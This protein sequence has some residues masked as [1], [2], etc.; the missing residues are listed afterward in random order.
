[1]RRQPSAS[2][3]TAHSLNA[4]AVN[5]LLAV[6]N[7]SMT[8]RSAM[9]NAETKP[10]KTQHVRSK[11]QPKILYESGSSIEE[12]RSHLIVHYAGTWD[13]GTQSRHSPFLK[14][15]LKA[16]QGWDKAAWADDV[17]RRLRNVVAT[18]DPT[19]QI[20]GYTI[21]RLKNCISIHT[22][23]PNEQSKQEMAALSTGQWPSWE[24]IIKAV[25][26][27]GDSM[28]HFD[29]YSKWEWERIWDVEEELSRLRAEH[30]I[31]Q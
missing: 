17:E 8:S 20:L 4:L 14:R 7:A 19:P 31:F 10:K 1:M 15:A 2:M 30:G 11:A 22:S 24:R 18:I 9:K 23:T 26:E 5:H 16:N 28:V 3:L 13:T 21:Q 6:D 29:A 12:L 27:L 25:P